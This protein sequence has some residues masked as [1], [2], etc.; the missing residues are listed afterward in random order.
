[1][2]K[3]ERLK[4]IVKGILCQYLEYTDRVSDIQM[5][6]TEVRSRLDS[7]KAIRYDKEPGGSAGISHDEQ[8]VIMI[9]R[10]DELEKLKKGYSDTAEAIRK[11]FRIDSLSDTEY[12]VLDTVY[13]TKTYSEAG[14]KIGYS[15]VQI[16][17]IMNKIY[18]K[19][20]LY[21]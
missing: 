19:L 4:A 15:T 9:E 16:Y 7:A 11:K 13:R 1:M 8:L 10:V 2:M 18:R 21:I 12:L 3:E 20:S 6:I 17:R 5:Q 14:E